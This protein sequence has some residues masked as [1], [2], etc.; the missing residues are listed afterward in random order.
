MGHPWCSPLEALK[1]REGDPFI[2]TTKDELWRQPIIQFTEGFFKPVWVRTNLKKLQSTLS[3]SFD[4]FSFKTV[5]L[6]FFFLIE[7]RTS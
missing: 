6:R 2:R 1:K 4:R 7:W 3:Y 5:D